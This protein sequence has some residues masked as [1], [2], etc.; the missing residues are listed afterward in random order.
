MLDSKFFFT[1]VG[2]IVAVFAICNTNMSPAISEGYWGN[3]GAPRTTRVVRE[4]HGQGKDGCGS[5]S[6][7]NNYQAMLGN[8]KFVSYPSMQGILSPRFGNTDFGAN[9]RYNMPSYKN[10]GVPCSPLQ[11]G[12]MAQEGYKEN[13]CGGTC[14]GGCGSAGVP[15]CGKG[16]TGGVKLGK[17]NIAG[18]TN[19]INAMNDLYDSSAYPD[20]SS[21]VAVGDMT[22]IGADGQQTQP[23]VYDRYIYANQKSRLAGLG[24][25]IRGDLPIV[26][27]NTGWFNVAANPSVDLREGAMNVMGGIGLDTTA[28]KLG[29]LVYAASGGYENIVAGVPMTTNMANQFSTSLGAGLGDVV[30]SAF[31]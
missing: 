19:Y 30:V 10:Q 9:I 4:V 23:I 20:A 27:C 29:E 21:L 3:S 12:D 11:F 24:D 2:L 13:Y 1:L 6:L 25:P 18:D 22:V 5:Y 8:N 28:A 26:P 15:S 31:P 16:G 7:Q 17:P 14:G